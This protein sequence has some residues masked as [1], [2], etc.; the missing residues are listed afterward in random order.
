MLVIKLRHL[1][2]DKRID[3]IS[4][5]MEL[6]GLS[7]NAINRIYKEEEPEKTELNTL[8]KLCDSLNCNLTDLIEYK[9]NN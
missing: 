9:P 4:E 7:R 3:T 5:L 6:S 1:M 8:L 2:A